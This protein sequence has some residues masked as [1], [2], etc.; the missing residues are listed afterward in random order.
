TNR[1]RAQTAPRPIEMAQARNQGY[2][3]ETHEPGEYDPRYQDR[4]SHAPQQHFAGAE[5]GVHL[6]EIAPQSR[7]YVDPAQQGARS[8][9]H[10]D[11]GPFVPPPPD[12]PV[13]RPQRMPQIDDLPLPA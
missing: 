10:Y 13:V 1:L 3:A 5:Q 4:G 6:Q 11:T 8:N 9:E 2:Q 12:S 7:Y